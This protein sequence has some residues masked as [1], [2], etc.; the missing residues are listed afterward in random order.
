MV[1]KLHIIYQRWTEAKGVPWFLATPI[2]S[3]NSVS[4]CASS[5][6]PGFGA[7]APVKAPARGRTARS[8]A[9]PPARAAQFTVTKGRSCPQSC[10]CSGSPCRR[11][12]RYGLCGRNAIIRWY[13]W[14]HTGGRAGPRVRPSG[15]R[16]CQLVVCQR[17]DWAERDLTASVT[18]LCGGGAAHYCLPVLESWPH[19]L[20]VC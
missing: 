2:S 20:P 13:R 19:F 6:H 7:R 18:T 12:E 10:G 8:P 9:A 5:K 1:A 16:P 17:D 3:R 14:A 4:W 15:R 11:G